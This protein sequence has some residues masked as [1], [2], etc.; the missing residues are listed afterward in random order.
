MLGTLTAVSGS[1]LEN[2]LMRCRASKLLGDPSTPRPVFPCSNKASPRSA[3]DDRAK[4][5]LRRADVMTGVTFLPMSAAAAERKDALK[6]LHVHAGPAV[7]TLRQAR[8]D[9]DHRPGVP[10]SGRQHAPAR[11]P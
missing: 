2:A 7:P 9:H 11:L 4:Q 10:G 3:Q 6:Y 8:E 5:Y 1:T